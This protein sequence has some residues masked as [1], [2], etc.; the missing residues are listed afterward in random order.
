MNQ[1]KLAQKRFRKA[2]KRKNK[3]YTGPKYSRLEQIVMWA[4]LLKRGG[5]QLF[6]EVN[7]VEQGVP[8]P[9]RGKYNVVK[10]DGTESTTSFTT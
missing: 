8:L 9:N 6:E 1:N 3:L 10:K 4:P 7:K 5:I 2:Q